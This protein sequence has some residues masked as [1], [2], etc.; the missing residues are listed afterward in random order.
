MV[1]GG[2]PNSINDD[3]KPLDIDKFKNWKP[4]ET[5]LSMH[6]DESSLSSNLTSME[7]DSDAA[8][9]IIRNIMRSK[10]K[11]KKKPLAP[12]QEPFAPVFTTAKTELDRQSALKGRQPPPPDENA[13]NRK[14]PRFTAPGTGNLRTFLFFFYFRF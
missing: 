11:P 12:K 14:I 2:I 4:N 3:K 1:S 6:L 10:P 9:P 7:V 8:S 5:I 13:G